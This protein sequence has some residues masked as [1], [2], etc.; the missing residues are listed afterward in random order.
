M[1]KLYC[2]ALAFFGLF[3]FFLVVFV[4]GV[5]LIFVALGCFGFFFFFQLLCWDFFVWLF[6]HN[7]RIDA[8]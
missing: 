5:H 1:L 8:I 6:F 2:Y 3:F 4:G 7:H